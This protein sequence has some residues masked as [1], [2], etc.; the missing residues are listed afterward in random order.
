MIDKYKGVVEI[1]IQG[2]K[3]GFKFGL[4]C[5]QLF[6][7][8]MGINFHEVSATLVR[9]SGNKGDNPEGVE[10]D[11]IMNF[12]LS[13]AQAYARLNK[14]AEPT[15]DDIYAWIEEVTMEVM[16]EKIRQANDL[17]D[18]NRGAPQMMGQN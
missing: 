11:T 8:R 6:A 18:P 15:I 14:Q 12:Y 3:R 7:E 1:E 4:R 5:N 2:A 9:A 10:I 17:P 16:S 13:A